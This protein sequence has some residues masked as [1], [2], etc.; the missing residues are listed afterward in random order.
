M[1]AYFTKFSFI[2][3]VTTEQG[4]WFTQVHELARELI[5]HA[6]DGERR[7]GIEAPLEVMAAALEFAEERDG[8]PGIQVTHDT[9][10]GSVWVCAE[11][12]G[13][14]EYTASLVQ[15]LLR[16]FELDLVVGF[17]WADTCSRLRLDGFGGGTVAVSRRSAVW[18][19][20]GAL[21]E[22]AVKAETERLKIQI[23]QGVAGCRSRRCRGGHRVRPRRRRQQPRRRGPARLPARTRL[24]ATSPSAAGGQIVTELEALKLVRAM[25]HAGAGNNLSVPAAQGSDTDAASSDQAKAIDLVDAFILRLQEAETNPAWAYLLAEQQLARLGS[26][27]PAYID[28]DDVREWLRENGRDD[29]A[30]SVPDTEICEEIELVLR[31]LELPLGWGDWTSEVVNIAAERLM[32]TTPKARSIE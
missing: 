32:E 22:K 28:A 18:F 29:L 16:H 19:S 26:V 5:A 21:L 27:A 3:P 2:V 17:E 15:A 30:D 14:V 24:E 10:A 6:E 8:L 31:K 4:A 11:E 7:E 23:R 12:C 1:V 13:D 25:A 9:G 20:T